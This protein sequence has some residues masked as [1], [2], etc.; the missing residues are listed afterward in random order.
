MLQVT[1]TLQVARLVDVQKMLDEIASR[2][3]DDSCWGGSD[4]L[5][6]TNARGEHSRYH[7]ELSGGIPEKQFPWHR[8]V[9]SD[10]TPYQPSDEE[11]ARV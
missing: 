11:R 6:F 2:L 7:F 8:V 10:G 3:E 4:T 9:N 1:I 5:P